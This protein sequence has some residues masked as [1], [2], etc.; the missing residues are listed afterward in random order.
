MLELASKDS[1]KIALQAKSV[2]RHNAL[3][4]SEIGMIRSSKK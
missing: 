4:R 3:Y 1:G 2:S